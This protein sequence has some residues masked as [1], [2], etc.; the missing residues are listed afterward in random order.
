MVEGG[1]DGSQ[2]QQWQQQ[3]N[4]II[5]ETHS[6]HVVTR[7]HRR[8]R[9]LLIFNFFFMLTRQQKHDSVTHFLELRS[10]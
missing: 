5:S 6:T 3:Q 4:Q 2:Q 9:A 8:F 7:L 1:E 10:C